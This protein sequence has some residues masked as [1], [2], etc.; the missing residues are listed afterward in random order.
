MTR[1]TSWILLAIFSRQVG[2]FC[3][4]AGLLF[5]PYSI[6]HRAVFGTMIMAGAIFY[7]ARVLIDNEEF[8]ENV[9][10]C[11]DKQKAA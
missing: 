8:L 7:L 6:D 5:F 2:A 10:S 9:K 11:L 3:F 4:F 1:W